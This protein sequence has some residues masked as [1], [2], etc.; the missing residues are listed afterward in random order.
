[1][2]PDVSI[3]VVTHQGREV[4]LRV[5]AAAHERL[6][7]LDAEWFL[8]D[9]GSS[10]GTPE[11]VAAAFP[12]VDVMRTPNIGFAAA[13]NLALAR[14]R[15]R[16]VLLL[17]PDM[18][19]VGGTLADLVE[20]MDRR[21]GVGIGSAITR[22][23]DGELQETIRRFPSP[24]RQ[25]GEALALTRLRAFAHL[26]EEEADPAAYL[27]ERSTDWLVGGFLL[28]RRE[29]VEQAGG[30]D[31]RFFLFSEETDW[32]LRVRRAGWDIR[33]FPSMELT[34]HTGRASRPDLYAQNSWSKVLYARKHFPRRSRLV[35]RAA[36]VLRHAVRL[37]VFAPTALRDR[38]LRQRAAAERLAVLVVAGIVAPRYTPYAGP[39]PVVAEPVAAQPA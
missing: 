19:M 6:G 33:H 11:A 38:D 15:G 29:A 22:Y 35:F 4:V 25:L 3:I 16:Y 9:S 24:R 39:E 7:D 34:H 2:R 31:E 20:D 1:M 30:L 32:C 36:L 17:N 10:D 27:A 28:V 12:G 18:E 5:L 21:P 37:A 26:Q 8:V 13:N 14:A 23:P